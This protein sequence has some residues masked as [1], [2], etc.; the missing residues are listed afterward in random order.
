MKK[1]RARDPA[2]DLAEKKLLMCG[3]ME[4]LSEV[5]CVCVL[6]LFALCLSDL[7]RCCLWPKDFYGAEL[8]CGL[9]ASDGGGKSFISLPQQRRGDACKQ[10]YR[11]PA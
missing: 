8:A 3:C 6:M 5:K 11:Q 7:I 2:K 10:H 9:R 4:M 1:C